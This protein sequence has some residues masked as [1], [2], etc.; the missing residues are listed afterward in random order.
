MKRFLLHVASFTL[1]ITL[2]LSAITWFTDR[3]LHKSRFSWYEDWNGVNNGTINADV[4]IM[5]SSHARRGIHPMIVDSILHVN[6]YNLGMDGYMFDMQLARYHMYRKRNKAPKLIILC[7]DYSEFSAT[8]RLIDPGQLLPYLQDDEVRED[9]VKMGMPAYLQYLP[10]LKYQDHPMLVWKA[11]CALTQAHTD[12]PDSYKGFYGEH[13]E[14]NT[15]TFQQFMG[16]HTYLA[17]ELS[18][19][20]VQQFTQF[21]DSCSKEQIK[22]VL[23]FTPH[24]YLFTRAVRYRDSYI[25]FLSAIAAQHHTQLLNYNTDSMCYNTRYFGNGTHLSPKG[26]TLFSQKLCTDLRLD[27][28]ILK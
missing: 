12:R 28:H 19:G 20:V 1:T 18:D 23:V 14:W 7:V 10:F 22:V 3:G 15:T 27:G 4:L 21:L 25:A 13:L 9:A 8:K 2:L 6:S 16:E 24:Y 5:G 26:V 17:P 11:G